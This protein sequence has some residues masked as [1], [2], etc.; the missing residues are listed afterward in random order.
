[1]ELKGRTWEEISALPLYE[2]ISL[3]RKNSARFAEAALFEACTALFV[4]VTSTRDINA[5]LRER[6]WPGCI[7][8]ACAP[9]SLLSP[10]A[11]SSAAQ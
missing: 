9:P 2:R 11:P 5:K 8:A 7:K 4:A 1:M 6:L 3:V 10:H